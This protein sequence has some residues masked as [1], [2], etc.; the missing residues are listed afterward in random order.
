MHRAPKIQ[1]LILQSQP[2]STGSGYCF[3]FQFW[4]AFLP[5]CL[6]QNEDLEILHAEGGI[7]VQVLQQ[8]K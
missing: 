3:A 2:D 1:I 5:V 7:L 4:F 8:P 6:V